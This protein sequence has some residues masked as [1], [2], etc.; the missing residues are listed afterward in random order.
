MTVAG[1][2]VFT[3]LFVA[4]LYSEQRRRVDETVD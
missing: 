2:I 4:L 3:F 1:V